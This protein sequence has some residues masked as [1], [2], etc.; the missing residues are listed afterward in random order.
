MGLAQ[1]RYARVAEIANEAHRNGV[2]ATMIIAE[3]MSVSLRYAS[4]LMNRARNAGWEIP[5]SSKTM[6]FDRQQ[7]I[8]QLQ[9][10][11]SQ[12]Q[13][14][15]IS[16]ADWDREGWRE[17]ANCKGINANLF[18]PE[19]GASGR[20]VD[21][22]KLVCAGCTVR[23]P[24]LQYAL[25]NYEMIGIWGGTS[26]RERRRIRSRLFHERRIVQIGIA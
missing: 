21:A 16:Q 18:F 26:E 8:E 23:R 9:W 2:P 3:S 11:R 14:V 17:H 10:W 20:D 4:T 25:D 22:A 1:E 7:A 13:G 15:V 5:Y 6:T 19:Q 12:H 24:C